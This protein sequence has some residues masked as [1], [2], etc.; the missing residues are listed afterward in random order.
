MEALAASVGDPETVVVISP[1]ADD[2]GSAHAVKTAERLHGDFGRFRC[3]DA[4][5]SYDNDVQFAELLLALAGDN[6]K[7]RL[8][9]DDGDVLDWGVLVPLELPAS[10]PDRQSVGGRPLCRAPHLGPA[11]APLRR[12]ARQGHAVPGLW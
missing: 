3:P 8:M 5:F 4:A 9:P 11:G 12:G 7:L 6:R 1:H 2:F 10:Q